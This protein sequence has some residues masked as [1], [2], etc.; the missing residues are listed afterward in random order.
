LALRQL[1]ILQFLELSRGVH[2]QQRHSPRAH[3]EFVFPMGVGRLQG[4]EI[5]KKPQGVEPLLGRLA[6][7]RRPRR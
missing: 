5:G 3:V 2:H 7:L 6:L 4:A 1:G